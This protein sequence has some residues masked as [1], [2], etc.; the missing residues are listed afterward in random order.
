MDPPFPKVDR[1]DFM[2]IEEPEM[3]ELPCVRVSEP[4]I[5]LK[6]DPPVRLTLPESAL[7]LPVVKVM[8][9]DLPEED[10]PEEILAPALSAA[11][12]TWPPKF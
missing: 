6:A 4:A 11:I 1:D 12:L 7:D 2:K 5:S 9:P 8:V 10:A 3:R